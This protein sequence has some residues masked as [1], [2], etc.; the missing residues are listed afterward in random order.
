MKKLISLLLALC[1]LFALA[2]CGAADD[3]ADDAAADDVAADDAAA[4]DA[5]ADDAAADAGE[6]YTITWYM[7]GAAQTDMPMVQ[8]AL[9]KYI[10]ETYGM[11][12]ALNIVMTP[13]GDLGQKMSMVLSSGE[14]W[15]L[16]YTATWANNYAQN[17]ANGAYLPL[18]EL[19][20]EYAPELYDFV[21]AYWASV[22]SDGHIWAVPNIQLEYK[23][24][25]LSMPTYW[26]DMY[27]ATNP[28]VKAEQGNY[29]TIADM[30]DFFYWLK[31]NV[32]DAGVELN[33]VAPKYVYRSGRADAYAYLME[34]TGLGMTYFKFGDET[35]TVYSQW[36]FEDWVA[37]S[38]V[39]QDWYNDGLIQSDIISATDFQNSDYA[40][41]LWM[42]AA[43][44]TFKP[45]EDANQALYWD[46]PVDELTFFTF[47]EPWSSTGAVLSTLTAVNANCKNPAVVMEFL[48]IINTDAT[49]FNMLCFGV[50]DYHYTVVDGCVQPSTEN[51]GYD[52]NCDWAFGNQFLAIPR[53]GQ[54]ADIWEVTAEMNETANVSCAMGFMPDGTPIET[55]IANVAVVTEQYD[56]TFGNGAMSGSDDDW[57]NF[58]EQYKTEYYAAGAQDVIDEIQ[59]QVDAWMAANA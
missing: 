43:H 53:A 8:E 48:N 25:F 41:G 34:D 9:A 55:Q 42:T 18:E 56:K 54:S 11:N 1:M 26:V 7:G 24:N 27:N 5:A 21:G 22:T 35:N 45:G 49:A 37:D 33:G 57:A 59:S 50:Q 3:A 23:Y 51:T 14:D 15:D 13:F 17:M 16:C 19:L 32:V 28:A 10:N 4:D 12:I 38:Y 58:I 20:P 46:L 30:N 52:P 6:T 31:T 2:A 36:D 39:F 40:S 47:G 29:E 44:P